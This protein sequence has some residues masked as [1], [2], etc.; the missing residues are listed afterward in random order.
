[1]LRKFRDPLVGGL[2]LPLQG[3]DQIDQP[4]SIDPAGAE[5]ILELLDRVHTRLHS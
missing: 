3:P 2:Q 4:I 1:L 5:V